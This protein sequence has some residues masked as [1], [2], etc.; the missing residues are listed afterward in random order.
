MAIIVGPA[1]NI[2]TTGTGAK[3]ATVQTRDV[4]GITIPISA[5]QRAFD[6]HIIWAS[7]Y[8]QTQEIT[9]FPSEV[10]NGV[11]TMWGSI[12]QDVLHI[13]FAVSLGYHLIP[14]DE[15]GE[16]GVYRIWANDNLIFDIS[17][18]TLRPTDYSFRFYPGSSQQNP[19]P[20]IQAAEVDR[21]VDFR[22][23]MYFVF[24]GFPLATANVAGAEFAAPGSGGQ[25]WQPTFGTIN[26]L[27][28]IRVE[29]IDGLTITTGITDFDMLSGSSIW[30][31][32]TIFD[33]DNDL[34][35]AWSGMNTASAK[36]HTLDLHTQTELSSVDITGSYLNLIGIDTIIFHDLN[37]QVALFAKNGVANTSPL[38]TVNL[39]SGAIIDTF[40]T[41]SLLTHPGDDGD[42]STLSSG[43]AIDRVPY[44]L[45]GDIG[46]T[47][48]GQ[49]EVSVAVLG[50]LQG[51]VSLL[52][53]NSGGQLPGDLGLPELDAEKGGAS[54]LLTT[55][56]FH[57][58]KCYPFLQFGDQIANAQDGLAIVAAGA[59][60]WGVQFGPRMIGGVQR[61]K[62]LGFGLI[63][64]YTADLPGFEPWLCIID[65]GDRG[66][67][68]FLTDSVTWKAIK[69]TPF[70]SDSFSAAGGGWG[71]NSALADWKG[72]WPDVDNIGIVP[73]YKAWQV[74]VPNLNVSAGYENS[75]RQSN[76]QAGTYGWNSGTNHYV[77]QLADGRVDTV[78]EGVAGVDDFVWDSR[79]QLM[80]FPH[81]T[82]HTRPLGIFSVGAAT[83]TPFTIGSFARW[84]LLYIGFEDAQI[85]VDSALDDPVTGMIIDH[86]R[87]L[88]SLMRDLGQMYNF[89]FF[90][91][92]GLAKLTRTVQD[93][94]SAP[95]AAAADLT[96]DDLCAVQENVVAEDDDFVT[97]LAQPAQ[98]VSSVSVQYSDLDQ[99]YS[100]QVQTFSIDQESSGSVA[101][102][103]MVLDL[104]VVMERADAFR[105][106]TKIQARASATSDTHYF[107][108]SQR[109]MTLEP[110]DLVTI[111]KPPFRYGIRI[112]EATFNGD[113][114]MSFSGTSF[115]F[116]DDIAITDEPVDGTGDTGNGFGTSDAKPVALDLP[117]LYPA[118]VGNTGTIVLTT[119]VYSYDEPDFSG[120]TLVY[121]D[122]PAGPFSNVGL[123]S[124]D[125]KYGLAV[126]TLADTDIPFQTDE[127]T[128]L[129]VALRSGD[130][131]T[132][133]AS[134]DGDGL[135][136]GLNT[137]VIGAAGRW[138]VVYFRD[139]A[140]ITDKV[141]QLSG[142]LRG[143]RGTE[144]NCGT[145]QANDVVI[146]VQS[147]A[148]DF[149]PGLKP[150]VISDLRL[151]DLL[152][153]NTRSTP[154][155]RPPAPQQLTVVGYSEY[156]WAPTDIHAVLGSRFNVVAAPSYL[157]P[158]GTGDRQ[159]LIT[160]TAHYTPQTGGGTGPSN[161]VDG[162]L[163]NSAFDSIDFA[164]GQTDVTMTFDFSPLG[165]PQIITEYIWRQNTAV[166]VGVYAFEGSLDGVS[167]DLLE[168]GTN[169]G[170]SSSTTTVSF[171]NST[172]YTFYRLR[173]VS[174]TTSSSPWCREIEFKT[175]SDI[176]ANDLLFTWLRRD[177]LHV[178]SFV[179]DD[180]LLSAP[181]QNEF[182]FQAL[183]AGLA[184]HSRMISFSLDICSHRL[185]RPRP[186]SLRPLP[187]ST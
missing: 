64:D 6:G 106:A 54:I 17:K 100:W 91:S 48:D 96:L 129:R 169:L 122:A 66:I 78:T 46:Y 182:K 154:A 35:Y 20:T 115:L 124:N 186:A 84:I 118:W 184:V 143:R 150:Q 107:R 164:A 109:Y 63:K 166:S 72:R 149:T 36:L 93:T 151:G 121:G 163:G 179:E 135:L 88:S 81:G 7:D 158:G 38:V 108:L 183:I 116:Q 144:V 3:V 185:I 156:P 125:T 61:I 18:P 4:Y 74:D 76:F 105:R 10:V 79:T 99:S 137:I 120:A 43:E 155:I 140:K 90:E 1:A 77:M 21:T 103:K 98:Q 69:Y 87:D 52:P 19:D 28:R 44:P 160:V 162:A 89:Q 136:E 141:L 24:K 176:G 30:E 165:L 58:I 41:A 71:N 23:M 14:E 75:T 56:D 110:S 13:D 26:E 187:K 126:G 16:I 8:Y 39:Q 33:W 83:G 53:I 174:G 145:H 117:L 49:V 175:Q 168:A 62:V 153:Y 15:R 101:S 29:L 147:V 170:G 60:L 70:V 111:T 148:T 97:V 55:D 104:P 25:G 128:T 177:R 95:G 152:V 73:A 178:G 12:A 119:G 157:N 86:P 114:S 171:A 142:L 123:F 134:T 167:Y 146:L 138:E 67:I 40:G 127:T 181:D 132:D 42:V 47:L 133:W 9:R 27:P 45:T 68:I 37:N 139:V 180:V 22:N 50:S 172:A 173:Q 5:G 131:D 31:N 85:S 112:S 92:E 102:G 80:Y 130:V 161:L 65:P 94:Q 32:G 57:F 82:G 59:K 51:D 34:V 113:W 11:P 2:S 159:S